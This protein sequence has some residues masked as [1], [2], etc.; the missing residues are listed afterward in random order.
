MQHYT[1]IPNGELEPISELEYTNLTATDTANFGTSYVLI[2]DRK[3][4]QNTNDVVHVPYAMVRLTQGGNVADGS[5]AYYLREGEAD[6]ANRL[7]AMADKIEAPQAV[8]FTVDDGYIPTMHPLGKAITDA[9][10]HGYTRCVKDI[11]AKY[12]VSRG[13]ELKPEDRAAVYLEV[14]KLTQ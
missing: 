11:L 8:P 10:K 9:A 5:K 14:I 13:S 3:P 2:L 12:N 6:D 7:K 4:Y 1:L